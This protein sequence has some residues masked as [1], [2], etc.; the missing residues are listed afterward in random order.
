MFW[1]SIYRRQSEGH[2]ETNKNR[3]SH[4]PAQPV[5]GSVAM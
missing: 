2:D 4:Q 1:A 3:G 5:R